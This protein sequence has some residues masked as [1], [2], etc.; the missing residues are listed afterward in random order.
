MGKY[1]TAAKAGVV[2]GIIPTI[3]GTIWGY[4]TTSLIME[5]IMRSIAAEVP[6]EALAMAKA[7]MTFGFVIGAVFNLAFM[8]VI[9]IVC[10]LIVERLKYTWP[11]KGLI[12]AAIYFL[13][14]QGLSL[15]SLAFQ[16]VPPE[17]MAS[18]RE[19]LGNL[20]IIG[21]VISAIVA[22][23]FGLIYAYLI[24]KWLEESSTIS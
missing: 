14:N 15:I 18:I 4:Y 9:G 6:P 11:V 13:F 8:A 23:V 10:L 22:I 21:Y 19:K 7:M 12:A 24:Y 3:V 1:T 20:T 16:Q 2:A 17:V 5:D